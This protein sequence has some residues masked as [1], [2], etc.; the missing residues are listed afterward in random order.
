MKSSEYKRK[1]T[2]ATLGLKNLTVGYTKKI[3]I[4]GRKYPSIAAAAKYYK[5]GHNSVRDRIKKG[6]SIEQAFEL[7]KEKIITWKNRDNLSHKE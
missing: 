7:K 5:I 3:V 1:F 2:I 4:E 6:W